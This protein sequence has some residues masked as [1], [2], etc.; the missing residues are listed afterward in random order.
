M[1][2]SLPHPSSQRAREVTDWSILA[3]FA[4]CDEARISAGQTNR[5]W[6]KVVVG[7]TEFGHGGEFPRSSSGR[8]KEKVEALWRY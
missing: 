6:A 2:A 3:W 5:G 4:S 8:L 1:Q 7:E